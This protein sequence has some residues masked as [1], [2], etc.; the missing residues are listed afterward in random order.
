VGRASKSN[1][2]EIIEWMI[3]LNIKASRGV[4]RDRARFERTTN[5]N[6]PTQE[7]DDM[8]ST[9]YR[10]FSTRI[11]PGHVFNGEPY[12]HWK[13]V[14]CDFY[15][16]SIMIFYLFIDLPKGYGIFLIN[17]P[18]LMS[19]PGITTPKFPGHTETYGRTS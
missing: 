1:L 12:L 7:S 19:A 15:I 14:C 18:E 13:N 3:I 9:V 10:R 8:K 2:L 4:H 16:F 6:D 11:A 5:L 17:V